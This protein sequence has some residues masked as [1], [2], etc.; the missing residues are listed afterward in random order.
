MQCF[1]IGD[2]FTISIN[3]DKFQSLSIPKNTWDQDSIVITFRYDPDP[4]AQM[5]D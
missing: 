3:F 2:L 4:S 1:V 5:T